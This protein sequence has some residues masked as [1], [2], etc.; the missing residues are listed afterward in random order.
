MIRDECREANDDTANTTCATDAGHFVDNRKRLDAQIAA[1]EEDLGYT[2]PGIPSS[3]IILSSADADIT[4]RRQEIS[5][6][7]IAIYTDRVVNNLREKFR[8]LSGTVSVTIAVAASADLVEQVEQWIH[9]Y[10]EAMTNVLRQ[11]VGDWG[12]GIFFP[13][14]YDVQTSTTETWRVWIRADRQYYLHFECEPELRR[15]IWEV[16]FHRIRIDFTWV[17]KPLTDK[18]PRLAA[19]IGF[20]RYTWRLRRP[21]S[22]ECEETKRD[23]ER[24]SAFQQRREKSPVF[25]YRRT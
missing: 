20:R 11:N 7:R 12:N 9:F 19:A 21:W 3:Q 13:G 16:I 25:K 2:L 6:P 18:L 14:T 23:R 24:F 15:R 10:I 5:Y 22:R 17:M 8:T 4:D 1:V